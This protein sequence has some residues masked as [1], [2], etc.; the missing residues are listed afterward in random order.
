L[1]IIGGV[2]T[3]LAIFNGVYP[4]ISASSSSI[5]SATAKVSDRIESRIV[6]IQAGN[7]GATVEAWLKNIG[8][9]EITNINQTDIFF[10]S[11]S[12]FNRIDYGTGPDLPYWEYQIEGGS[13]G[14]TQAATIKVTIHF[15]EPP[16]PGNYILK[17]VIP[18]G[19]NDE[20]T[21]SVE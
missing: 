17:A 21:F 1:L 16:A 14:W 10:G 4:S 7:N 12:S 18:N 20:T 5:S 11:V 3:S 6:I 19:I 2:V 13:S 9:I 8:T 15:T